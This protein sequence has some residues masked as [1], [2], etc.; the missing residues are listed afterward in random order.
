MSK[1][2]DIVAFREYTLGNGEKRSDSTRIGVAW[3]TRN[4]NFT[5]KLDLIPADVANTTIVVMVAA[6]S[7][8]PPSDAIPA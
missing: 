7:E 2:H 5:L 3:P 4:G 8:P 1:P 6:K